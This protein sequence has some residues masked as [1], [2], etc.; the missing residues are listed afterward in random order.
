MKF[1]REKEEIKSKTM[2]QNYKCVKTF[3]DPQ[4]QF[5]F[6]EKILIVSR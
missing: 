3:Q 5:H 6:D 1:Y 2:R 4:G